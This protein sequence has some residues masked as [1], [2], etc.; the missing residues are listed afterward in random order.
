MKEF[1][2]ELGYMCSASNTKSRGLYIFIAIGLAAL[3]IGVV[4]SAVMIVV[5]IVKFGIVPWMGIG[6][7]VAML[8]AL[9]GLIIWLKKS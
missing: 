8:A 2:E 5:N 6:L 4:A 1:F 7:L 9:I 3:A